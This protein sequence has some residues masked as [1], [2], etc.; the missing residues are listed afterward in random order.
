MGG[1][2]A[3]SDIF[4]KKVFFLY[5][6]HTFQ[7]DVLER[8]R[9]LEYE[10]YIINDYKNV[11]NILRKHPKSILF[12]NPDNYY[13]PGSWI[14]FIN[15]I[16]QESEFSDC[17]VGV[18]TE[19]HETETVR[20]F[21]RETKHTAGVFKMNENPDITLR[22]IV[23]SLDSFN[24]KGRRQYVR[25]SCIEDPSSEIF[26]IKN[27]IMFKFKIIDISAAGIAVQIPVRQI[28]TIRENQI[29]TNISL[30]LNAKQ[31]LINVKVFALKP[32]TE[33][34]T[35][36][37]MIQVDTNKKSLESIRSYVS[38][39]LHRKIEDSIFG[40][41]PDKEDYTVIERRIKTESSK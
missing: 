30:M 23:K 27:N 31:M 15:T 11:K 34:Y 3:E 22:E 2:M 41:P 12:I 19:R 26:W 36:I 32:G 28:R 38:E 40:M 20:R 6:S 24:A 5:P 16:E 39:T 4:G 14:K 33:F 29:I 9:T 21:M 37:L 17:E 1:F 10:S 7:S 8:L 35:G 13:T 18:I 25:A